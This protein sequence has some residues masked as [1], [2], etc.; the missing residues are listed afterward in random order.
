[1]PSYELLPDFSNEPEPTS[2]SLLLQTYALSQILKSADNNGE[3]AIAVAG[4]WQL[5]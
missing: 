2:S 5:M 3:I 1:M 4:R